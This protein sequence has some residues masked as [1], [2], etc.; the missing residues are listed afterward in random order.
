LREPANNLAGAQVVVA[1]LRG[2]VESKNL[3]EVAI[4]LASLKARTAMGS[5]LLPVMVEAQALLDAEA[6]GICENLKANFKSGLM[7]N[8]D[9][10]MQSS[11][12]NIALPTIVKNRWAAC[13][14]MHCVLS[15]LRARKL[16]TTHAGSGSSGAAQ[17][18]T[19]AFQLSHETKVAIDGLAEVCFLMN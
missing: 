19:V 15:K 16:A 4:T 11:S 6:T 12:Y 13:Y 8:V 5:E 10:I 1:E 9:T 17:P 3:R 7:V 18:E 14:R 2:L